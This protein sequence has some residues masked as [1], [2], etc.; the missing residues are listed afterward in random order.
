MFEALVAAIAIYFLYVILKPKKHYDTA[1]KSNKKYNHT[2]KNLSREELK[3][4]AL[5]R[6]HEW[7]PQKELSY[8]I[9]SKVVGTSF[10]N[11]DGSSRQEYI[12]QKLKAG[13]ELFLKAYNYKGNP[14]LALYAE[15]NNKNS[16]IG[17]ISSSLTERIV[18]LPEDTMIEIRVRD[19]TGGTTEKKTFGVNIEI[20]TSRKI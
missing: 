9:Y 20:L 18:Q 7:T 3:R 13:D 2:S 4:A 17:H 16:Q 10:K 11:D 5:R 12:K 1:E 19:I 6:E 15:E 14:A 8:S